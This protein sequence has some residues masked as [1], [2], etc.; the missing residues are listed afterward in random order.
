MPRKCSICTS[1]KLADSQGL[2]LFPRAFANTG[3]LW[4]AIAT[5]RNLRRQHPPRLPD[6]LYVSPL[7][8]VF[9]RSGDSDDNEPGVQEDE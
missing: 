3:F 4:L 8:G 6:E 2:S 5:S 1:P 9:D 7:I